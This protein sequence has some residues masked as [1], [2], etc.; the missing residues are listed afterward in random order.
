MHIKDKPRA[1]YILIVLLFLLIIKMIVFFDGR[2]LV[3]L[4]DGASQ[5][6][7]AL[8]YYSDYL[9]EI[10]S[11]FI[12]GN[13]S[14][15]GWDLAIGEGSDILTTLHYYCIGD[16]LA[17]LSVFFPAESMFM[18]YELII[19]IRVI[20]SGLSFM[21][22][23]R[24]YDGGRLKDRISDL[25][26]ASGAVLYTF[27]AWIVMMMTRHP[28]F[29]NPMILM[30]LL[31]A[32]VEL[33]MQRKRFGQMALTVMIC[34][35]SNLYFLYIMALL[36]VIYVAVRFISEY[37]KDIRNMMLSL[38]RVTIEAVIGALM[39]AVILYPVGLV[40]IG[41][42][43]VGGSGNL[44]VFYPLDYYL[45]L[46]G[47]IMSGYWSYYLF[48]GV[49]VAGIFACY[50]A[51]TRKGRRPLKAYVIISAVCLIFPVLGLVLNGFAYASNRWAFAIP[52]ICAAALAVCFEDMTAM[53]WKDLIPLGVVAALSVA[54]SIYLESW[55]GI[56]MTAFGVIVITVLVFIR[57]ESA[58]PVI[59]FAAV[60]VSSLI[61]ILFYYSSFLPQ[62]ANAPWLNIYYYGSEAQYIR[63]I[64][65]DE[66][67]RY[68]GNI[69]TENVS[70]IAGISSTQF[71]WSNAN[72]YVGE[73]RTD[74]GSPEYRLYYYSGYDSS[75]AQLSLAGCSYYAQSDRKTEPEPYGYTPI[76]S[77][78]IGYTIKKADMPVNLLYTY[79]NTV[80]VSYWKSLS[81]TDRQM[82]I[83]D[84]MVTEDSPNTSVGTPP[85]T[86]LA[87]DITDGEEGR[88][89]LTFE[90]HP[91]SETYITVSNIKTNMIDEHYFFF[92]EVP[93]TEER[94][95][96]QYYTMSNWYNGRDEFTINLGWHEEAIN[97]AIVFVDDNYPY[98]ADLKASV[99]DVGQV[100][101]NIKERFAD[102]SDIRIETRDRGS[103]IIFETENDKDA[104]YVLAVPY[105]KGWRAYVDGIETDIM[106]ANLQYMGI[107]IPE[108]HHDVRFEYRSDAGTGMIISAAGI[109]AYIGY[110]V[111]GTI[112]KNRKVRG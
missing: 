8:T 16:P 51:L 76:D 14:I 13:F 31:L 30:P 54:S 1:Y 9:R 56:A 57:K 55:T 19:Y 11:N 71:Y 39:A 68:S 46:P 103:E 111:Y 110:M 50:I 99:I 26:L 41:D 65:G 38:G 90:G 47:A 27:S 69:L 75:Y 95:M 108:G 7:S 79:D 44:G 40:F 33:L 87:T 32:G 45:S 63:R 4:Y 21:Y 94:Y 85:S 20:L 100:E 28:F 101:N 109:I 88:K 60:S 97:E 107:E 64:A 6:L 86:M 17:V 82:L 73:Y 92:I 67:T 24:T 36:T 58:K 12:H 52:L 78:D 91:N 102:T 80:N 42:S 25:A 29:M 10:L 105:A 37:G 74:T 81:P 83:T 112:C 66:T 84:T 106:R 35:L 22:F 23:M 34:A 93:Q 62:L 96:F 2:V 43:R 3:W 53:T 72:P 59:I 48:I 49:G 5:H 15:P 70:P 89:I 98:T 77:M 104:Y 18:C 61:L